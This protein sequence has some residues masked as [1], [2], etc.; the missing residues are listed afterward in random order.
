ML[1]VTAV[2]CNVMATY[3]TLYHTSINHNSL[4]CYFC[5]Y[6]K[7]TIMHLET[8]LHIP[9]FY[10]MDNGSRVPGLEAFCVLLN[11]LTY[12]SR[13][14]QLIQTYGRSPSMIS[15]IFNHT[16]SDLYDRYH[17]KLQW[18]RHSYADFQQFSQSISAVSPL[19]C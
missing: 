5:R 17:T 13:L 1:L 19:D 6:D 9:H 3:F 8:A 2:T 4:L 11:R 15:R 18:I 12:P 14:T 10:S 16:L 7:D